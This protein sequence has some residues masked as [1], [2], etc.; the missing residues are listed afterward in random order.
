MTGPRRRDRD[1]RQPRSLPERVDLA[2]AGV[3]ERIE[4]APPGRPLIGLG[5][6]EVHRWPPAGPVSPARRLIG[7]LLAPV[8]GSLAGAGVY[9]SG[10][11]PTSAIPWFVFGVGAAAVVAGR[12]QAR[13]RQAGRRAGG[14]GEG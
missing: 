6:D 9:L 3:W 13:R 7:R 11:V 8:V 12:L 1:G 14:A 5:S 2:D 4:Q 10:A